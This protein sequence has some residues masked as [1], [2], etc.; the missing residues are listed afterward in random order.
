MLQPSDVGFKCSCTNSYSRY[1]I[2]NCAVYAPFAFKLHDGEKSNFSRVLSSNV[3]SL[4][5]VWL[6]SV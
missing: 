2:Y 1:L 3:L 6:G 4:M 5:S